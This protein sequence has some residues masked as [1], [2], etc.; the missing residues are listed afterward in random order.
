MKNRLY[1]GWP[2]L[3]AILLTGC[4]PAIIAGSAATLTHSVVEERSTIDALSDTEVELSISTRLGEHSGELFRDVS[5]DVV[6]QRVVL[7]GSVPEAGDRIDAETIAWAAPGVRAVTNDITVAEDAGIAS[8][9]QDVRVANEVRFALLS[10]KGVAN[11]NYNVTVQE[12]VVHLTGVAG[13]SD[14]LNRAINASRATS[15]VRKVVSHVLL[16]DDPR[17]LDTSPGGRG[18]EATAKRA[19]TVL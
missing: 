12:G 10:A 5:V 19:D 11:W 17:R 8:Y 2:A 14:E 4:G 7:T 6:E 13:S 1:R 9:W 15:G 18:T 16:V 3:A